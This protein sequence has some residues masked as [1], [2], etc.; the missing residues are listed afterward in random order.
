ML[1][2]VLFDLDDTLL[3]NDMDVFLPAYLDLLGRHAEA[4]VPRAAFIA[5]LLDSTRAMMAGRD[6]VLTNREVFWSRFEALTGE[7]REEMEPFFERFYA[8]QFA[9]L[10]PLT[11]SLADARRV[12]R[13]CLDRSL[14]VVIATNPVFPRAAL[15]ERLRWA[16]LEAEI[17]EVSLITSYE[18]MHHTKP[19]AAYYEEIVARLGCEPGQALMVGNDVAADIT[20]AAAAGLRTLLV[21][22]ASLSL[23]PSSED[24]PPSL[25]D[26]TPSPEDA[27]SSPEDATPSLAELRD[28]LVHL[29]R[30]G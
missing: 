12:V 1:E 30:L 14:K 21:G 13:A 24:A 11:T 7:A 16:G 20:P 23:K 18:V 28:V 9:S 22:S 15:V 6:G 10:E 19:H 3:A 25:H 17:P 8:E 27:T 4:R 5:A 29:E 2:A 26:M